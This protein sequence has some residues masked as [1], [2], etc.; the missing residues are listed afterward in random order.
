MT[1]NINS[2]NDDDEIRTPFLTNQSNND[3]S[4]TSQPTPAPTSDA[5]SVTAARGG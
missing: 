5:S 1:T 2:N 3:N 4:K